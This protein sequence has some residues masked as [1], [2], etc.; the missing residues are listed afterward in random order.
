LHAVCD[1]L[2]TRCREHTHRSFLQTLEALLEK[3]DK[4]DYILVETTGERS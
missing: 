2:L 3:R 4:F 1:A